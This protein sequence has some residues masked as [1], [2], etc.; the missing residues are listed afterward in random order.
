MKKALLSLLFTVVLGFALTAQS[1]APF[2]LSWDGVEIPDGGSVYLMGDPNAAEIV[3][4]AIIKN[5]KATVVTIKVRRVEKQ[6]IATTWNQFCWEGTCYSPAT[7]ES[8]YSLFTP[9]QSSAEDS[10]SAHYVPMGQIGTTICEYIF[11]NASDET[12]KVSFTVYFSAF[13][14]SVEDVLARSKFSSAYPNPARNNISFD[15]DFPNDVK[16]ASIRVTNMLGKLVVD[17]PIHDLYGKITLPVNNLT[18][19]VYFYSLVLNNQIARTQK[20]IIQK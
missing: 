11:L 9:G 6:V 2:T 5:N 20:L 14:A 4:H 8:Q 3:A 12:E 15:Y 16:S 18:E 17:Q 13:P 1:V 7:N 19:G 10:F